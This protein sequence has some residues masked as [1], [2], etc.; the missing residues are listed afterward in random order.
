ME[1]QRVRTGKAGVLP[2]IS[3]LSNVLKHKE[4]PF[5]RKY[6]KSM[7]ANKKISV[8]I[9]LDYDPDAMVIGTHSRKW[10][11]KILMGSVTEELLNQSSIPLF[12]I[13]TKKQQ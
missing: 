13:P 5:L 3:M 4:P 7:K 9:A 11:E 10:L 2:C 6:E 12:I 8:L 1:S